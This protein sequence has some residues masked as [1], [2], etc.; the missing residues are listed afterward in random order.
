M[1][2]D[3]CCMNCFWQMSNPC[4]C[5]SFFLTICEKKKDMKKTF[6]FLVM[7][8]WKRLADKWVACVQETLCCIFIVPLSNI[9]FEFADVVYDLF[10][11]VLRYRFCKGA[12]VR[13]L[14]TSYKFCFEYANGRLSIRMLSL[15]KT[16]TV[17]TL[18]ALQFIPTRTMFDWVSSLNYLEA[19]GW[20]KNELHKTWW[21]HGILKMV[22]KA[23]I[24]TFDL[25]TQ[26]FWM[27]SSQDKKKTH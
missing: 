7:D 20:I 27:Y 23:L 8:T 19:G 11:R 14:H 3:A 13:P 21:T 10:V 18:Y 16:A 26:A 25:Q 6:G 1:L 24:D 5:F 15:E 17:Y 9:V 2:Q 4:I 12:S 22:G